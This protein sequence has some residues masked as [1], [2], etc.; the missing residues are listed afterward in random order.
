MRL[1]MTAKM[2][3]TGVGGF[4]KKGMETE[5][6]EER[7]QDGEKCCFE[8]GQEEMWAGLRQNEEQ[9]GKF[10]WPPVQLIP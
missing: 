4:K 6:L 5:R 7:G 9:R 8:G 3:G 10:P 1:S 2:K